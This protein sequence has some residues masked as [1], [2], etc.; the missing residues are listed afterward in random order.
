MK[1]DFALLKRIKLMGIGFAM[2]IIIVLFI[3]NGKKTKCKWFPNARI[4][5]IIQQK[6]ITYSSSINKSIAFKAIDST[7]INNFLING[8]IDF[9]KSQ[10]KNK[11][12]RTYWI[13]GNVNTQKAVLHVKICDS[14]AII[15]RIDYLTNKK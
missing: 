11:P 14:I 1:I 3:F 8:K 5:N 12:C 13:N 10:V 6:K 15:E 4:L 2:G 7:D 9:S